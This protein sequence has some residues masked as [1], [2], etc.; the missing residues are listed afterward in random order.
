MWGTAV[1]V[2]SDSA[3]ARLGWGA[4]SG[5]YPLGDATE[6]DG[7]SGRGSACAGGPEKGTGAALTPTKQRRFRMPSSQRADGENT[8]SPAPRAAYPGRSGPDRGL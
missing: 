7:S 8:A 5:V 1:N 6:R 4:E 3:S 2:V